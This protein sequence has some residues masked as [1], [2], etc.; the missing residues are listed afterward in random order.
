M[1]SQDSNSDIYGRV[2]AF[3]SKVFYTK[4]NNISPFY[5]SGGWGNALVFQTR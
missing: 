1:A 5:A 2:C 3:E 4:P